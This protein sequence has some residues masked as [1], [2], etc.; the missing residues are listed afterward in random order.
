M[1]LSKLQ[2]LGNQCLWAVDPAFTVDWTQR[3]PG[4]FGYTWDGK[5]HLQVSE[6][7]D[8][9]AIH[10]V[11][12][13][14]ICSPKRLKMPEFGLGPDPTGRWTYAA[15]RTVTS[16][17]AQE[18]ESRACDLHWA[19]VAYTETADRVIKV[20]NYLGMDPPKMKTLKAMEKYEALPADFLPTI[21]KNWNLV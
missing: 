4:A 16:K 13:V 19:L 10:D 5:G 8:H 21:L 20:Q 11:A 7:H 1:S 12:H 2:A 6:H 18:E 15:S 14:M 17:F 9:L 3:P